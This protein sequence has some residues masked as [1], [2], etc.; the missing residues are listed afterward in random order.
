MRSLALANQKGGVGKTTTAVHLAHGLS[1][2]GAR[3][4]LLDLDPQGNATLAVQA[5]VVE[6]ATAT[7]PP[8]SFL[9]SLGSGLWMLP[10]SGS[11]RGLA[12]DAR[13]DLKALTEFADGLANA[14]F[15]WLIVDCPPRMDQWAWAGLALCQEVLVPVQAEFLAMHG[16]SQMMATLRDAAAEFPGH[17]RLL[18]VLATMLDLREP[19]SSEILRDLRS[20]LGLQLLEAIVL[21]DSQ[22]VEAASHGKTIFEYNIFSKGARSYLE[23]VR[24]V[25]HGRTKVG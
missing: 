7:E 25:I 3:V 19:V 10:S 20:N 8:Y 13:P 18:G 9:Q 11:E 15:D 4:A 12:R 1:L 23:L 14:G 6:D 2:S 21:R 22:L 17:A 5:M 16:L 24:E